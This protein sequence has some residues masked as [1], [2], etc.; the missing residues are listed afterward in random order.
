VVLQKASLHGFGRVSCAGEE[1]CLPLGNPAAMSLKWDLG[2]WLCAPLFRAVCP[3]PTAYISAGMNGNFS[4]KDRLLKKM[5]I[6]DLF[7]KPGPFAFQGCA[8]TGV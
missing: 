4:K 1:I 5:E 8:G 6:M 2:Q 3:F 7:E